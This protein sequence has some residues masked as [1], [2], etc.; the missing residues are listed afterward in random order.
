MTVLSFGPLIDKNREIP[1][2]IN[3]RCSLTVDIFH[4][5]V[6]APAGRSPGDGQ[7]RSQARQGVRG[8]A[9]EVFREIIPYA[10]MP[11]RQVSKMNRVYTIDVIKDIITPI[12]MRYGVAAV[13]LF[14][15]YARG[16][17]TENSDVDLLIDH[18]RIRNLFE[19]TAFRLDCE[20]ALG[21]SVDVVTLDAMSPRFS[22]NVHNDE[23]MIFDAA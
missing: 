19:L 21:K 3:A 23:V 15:S 7:G 22:G 18:G 17:A 20:E 5:T 8:A 14:G 10:I 1:Y 13:W 2:N 9:Q 12:A 16:E 6:H 11:E 4:D